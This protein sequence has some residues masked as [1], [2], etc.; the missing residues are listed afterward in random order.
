MTPSVDGIIGSVSQTSQKSSPPNPGKKKSTPSNNTTSQP[1]LNS[2][3]TAEV[4]VVQ[5]NLADKTSKGK[6][7][8]KGKAKV[9]TQK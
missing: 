8:G 5:A 7:K 2:G 3:K 1:T 6:K 4:N 9:D